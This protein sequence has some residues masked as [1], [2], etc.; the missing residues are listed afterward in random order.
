MAQRIWLGISGG[1]LALILSATLLGGAVFAQEDDEGSTSLGQQFI[2]R[3]AHRLGISSDELKSAVQETQT[4]MVDE[5]LADGRLTEEQAATMKE[6]IEAGEGRFSCMPGRGHGGPRHGH[7]ILG[8]VLNLGVIAD[9]LDITTDELREQLAG[10]ATLAEIIEDNG[11]SVDGIIAILI[12]QAQEALDQA[13]ANG[14]I[15]QGQA[16]E[17]LPRLTERLTELIES[18]LSR[19]MH[20]QPDVDTEAT[21]TSSS[22]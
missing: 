21:E 7:G 5:A 17:M 10:G 9:E 14:R 20:F 1:A 18:G 13:V 8:R 4:E 16:D 15:T 2:E 19:P 22:I 6:R 3:L 12:A 11:G